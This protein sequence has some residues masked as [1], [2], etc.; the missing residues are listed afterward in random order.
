MESKRAFLTRS[1]ALPEGI[2]DVREELAFQTRESAV[3]IEV[4][5]AASGSLDLGTMLQAALGNITEL[6]RLPAGQVWIIERDQLSVKARIGTALGKCVEKDVRVDPCICF[7]CAGSGET[8]ALQDLLARPSTQDIPCA[9]AGFRSIITVPLKT[10]SQTLGVAVLASPNPNEFAPEQRRI[11]SASCYC[12]AMA[13]ENDQLFR[14]TR[15]RCKAMVALHETSLGI[16]AQLDST[17]LLEEMLRRATLLLGAKSCSLFLYDR[18]THLIHNIANYNNWRDWTGVTL[19]PGEGVI[20]QVVLTGK[21][22]I[23]HDYANWEHKHNMKSRIPS[24]RKMGAPLRWQNQVI[25][26][27]VVA[28]ELQGRPFDDDDLWLF[29]QF[30]D[31]ASIAVKNAVFYS[32]VRQFSQELENQVTARTFELYRAK[33]EI[34]AR[35]EQLR[36][37]LAKTI[38]VQEDERARIARDMHDGALQ[39]INAARYQVQAAEIVAGQELTPPAQE[40]LVT[41]RELLDEMEQEIRHAIGNL[42]PL[43]LDTVGLVPAIEDYARRLQQISG[44]VCRFKIVGALAKLP[45][46]SENGIYHLVQQALSN[47]TAH[48]RATETWITLDY[49]TSILC[50]TVDDNGCGFDEQRWQQEAGLK[51]KHLGL[52]GMHIEPVP[53]GGTHLS[54]WLPIQRE[55]HEQTDTSFDR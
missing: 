49:Q 22:V 20:G 30:A 36:L 18:Q 54:F 17:E 39:L 3:P 50:I 43:I 25:G 51:G 5:Q 10:K 4:E 7:E 47:V 23:V 13:V 29:S 45:K 33:E 8:I 21:P 15:K 6:L 46:E 40:K 41:T 11:L 1:A 2:A 44:M 24:T 32:Q 31:L 26:G 52:L 28:N 55:Q 35:S 16:I 37:L 19:Q 34:A 38:R 27:V 14:E 53:G 12:M 42:R 48:S 9:R